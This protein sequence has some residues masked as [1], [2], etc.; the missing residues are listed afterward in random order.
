ML[1]KL[2]ELKP[3]LKKMSQP[4]ELF[5]SATLWKQISDYVSSYGPIRAALHRLQIENAPLSEFFKIWTSC[6]LKT[7]KIGKR[8][9]NFSH[10]RSIHG[11]RLLIFCFL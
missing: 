5:I 1:N 6:L 10:R 7:K 9:E 2:L 8:I 4:K 11:V 3:F